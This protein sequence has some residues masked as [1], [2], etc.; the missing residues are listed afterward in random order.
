MN[1]FLLAVPSALPGG[2][3]AAMGMHF[4]HCDIFTLVEIEEGGIKKVTTM[5]NEPHA[6]GGC[7]APVQKLAEQGVRAMLAGGMG[8]RPLQAFHQAGIQVFFSG[9][10]SSV[11]NAVQAFLAG[12]L[13]EFTQDQTCKGHSEGGCSG[14]H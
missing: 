10:H 3:D 11:E 2:L 14:H 12:K 13:P 7:L 9:G 1:S 6:A 8:A 4:G 5:Q